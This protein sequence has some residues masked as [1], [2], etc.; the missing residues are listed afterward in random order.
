VLARL[1]GDEFVLVQENV[2]S[3]QDAMRCAAAIVDSMNPPFSLEAHQV[4]I[5]ASVGVRI[6]AGCRDSAELLKGADIALYRAKRDGRR[7]FVVFDPEMQQELDELRELEHTIRH[8]ADHGGFDLH[9]QPIW[10]VEDCKLVGFEAL[11][12]LPDAR[13]KLIPPM[14]FIPVA[15]RLGLIRQIGAWVIHEACAVAA[16][17]PEHLTIA[18]NL[19]PLQFR[20]GANTEESISDIV[21][22]ALAHTRLAAH[23]LELEVT[24][25]ALLEGSGS[26]YAELQKLRQIGLSLVI[27]DFGTGY[28]SLNYIWK[29]PFSKIKLDRAFVA[30]STVAESTIAAVVRAITGLAQTLGLR[31][32]VEGIESSEQVQL[33][34]ELGCHEMQGYFLGRPL[35]RTQIAVTILSD[36]CRRENL[37]LTKAAYRRLADAG[38]KV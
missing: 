9:F 31:V 6:S 38:S 36:F 24:E 37:G 33:F 16:T 19:S 7:R 23:R 21:T 17:W 2:T 12:R 8:A 13:G 22:A 34:A 1:G 3:L 35:P 28:S 32:T 26:V 20:S 10:R 5:S 30:G 15:E 4:S 14:V 11:L 25:N 27:D 18:V 29:F